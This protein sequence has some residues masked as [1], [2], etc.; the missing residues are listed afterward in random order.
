ML[1]ANNCFL[2][3]TGDFKVS[4]YYFRTEQSHGK[5]YKIRI[6]YIFSLVKVYTQYERNEVEWCFIGKEL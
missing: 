3:S 5:G 2:T 4:I 6:K 1:G